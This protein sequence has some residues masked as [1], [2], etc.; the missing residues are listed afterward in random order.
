MRNLGLVVEY[1]PFHHGH[2]VH[3]KASKQKIR[4]D[5]TIAVM[6]GSFLQ[7]GEPALTDKWTRAEMALA[8][9]IDLVVELPYSYAV[10]KAEIFAEGAVALLSKLG[11]TDVCFG[12][13]SGEISPFHSTLQWM[14]KHEFHMSKA[15][16]SHLKEGKSYP[17]S[18]SDAA[19]EIEDTPPEIDLSRPNN[20]LG[21]HYVKA[22]EQYAITSHT[23]MREGAGYHDKEPASSSIAS[24]TALRMKLQ[25]G[26][27]ISSLSAFTPAATVQ[28]LTE[29]KQRFGLLH[30]WNDYYPFFQ[31]KLFTSSASSLKEIYECEEGLENRLLRFRTAGSFDEFLEKMKTKR[32]TRTRLQRLMTHVLTGASKEEMINLAASPPESIRVLGMNRRGRSY[33]NKIKKDLDIPLVTRGAEQTT[34]S[35]NLSVKAADI[36]SLPLPS[37][38]RI[39][40]YQQKIKLE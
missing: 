5:V 29:Y 37:N 21:Y 9:G 34:R 38:K 3:L 31:Y 36:H 1:N 14:K 19:S 20:I 7:R 39:Y 27:P 15:I 18:F 10:Q 13:E 16:S 17:R 30:S 26:A 28:L 2:S 25:E 32:Y 8:Q 24:A 33:L 22:A 11:V 23:I 6:S 12:S 35:D 40:E 4:P